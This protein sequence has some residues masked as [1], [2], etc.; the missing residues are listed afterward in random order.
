MESKKE[1]IINHLKNSKKK[2]IEFPLEML[3]AIK[4]LGLKH[5]FS[6]FSKSSIII[7]R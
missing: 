2:F 3:P 4:E 6:C 1:R 5:K 7:V